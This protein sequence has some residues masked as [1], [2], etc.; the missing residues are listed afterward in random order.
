MTDIVDALARIYMAARAAPGT[1]VTN[2]RLEYD[3]ILIDWIQRDVEVFGRARTDNTGTLNVR[4]REFLA[5]LPAC[6]LPAAPALLEELLRAGERA[7][8]LLREHAAGNDSG[9]DEAASDLSGAMQMARLAVLWQQPF[10]EVPVLTAEDAADL[11]LGMAAQVAHLDVPLRTG[12]QPIGTIFLA[13]YETRHFSF[14][15]TGLT[16]ADA[17]EALTEVMR[18]HADQV[19]VDE[20]WEDDE[21][22]TR[23]LRIGGGYRD[24]EAL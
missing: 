11:P 23:Q 13:E 1:E 22:R 4:V 5:S 6:P 3:R 24:G 12:G 21:L 15:G 8:E 7:V 17:V 19:G 2:C 20:W 14:E 9:E 10:V 18:K 16:E